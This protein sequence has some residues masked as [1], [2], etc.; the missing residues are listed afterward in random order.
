VILKF[1]RKILLACLLCALVP[2]GLAAALT[3]WREPALPFS[4]AQIRGLLLFFGLTVGL[5]FI[6]GFT[7]AF[8]LNRELQ[9]MLSELRTALNQVSP[10][11]APAGKAPLPQDELATLLAEVTRRLGELAA[12][13]E[14]TLE[15]TG[16]LDMSHLL[17]TIVARATTLMGVTGGFIYEADPAR[18]RLRLAAVKALSPDPLGAEMEFGEG[19]AGRVAESGESLVIH[20]YLQW[21]GR[22]ERFAGQPVFNV[23]GVPMRWQGQ[24]IGVLNLE[25]ELGGRR[26]TAPDV[27]LAEQ[28][29][30]QAA[31]AMGN[32]RL[33]AAANRQAERLAIMHQ[34]SQ[35]ILSRSLDLEQV[36]EAIDRAVGQLMPNEAMTIGLLDDQQEYVEA[37]YLRDRGVRQPTRRVSADASLTGYM[38]K[39][40]RPLLF[41]S[42]EEWPSDVQH[43]G[44]EESVQSVL[45]VPL[46]VGGYTLGVLTTQSYQPHA[47]SEDDFPL[48]MTLANQAAA[49][50]QNA[51]LFQSVQRQVLQL[52]ILHAVA[53]AAVRPAASDPEEV[54]R[55]AMETL[56][57]RVNY[58]FLA[59]LLLNPSGTA[60]RPYSFDSGRQPALPD[61]EI[62]L[63][64]GVTGRVA[65][66]G[67]PR[68][69]GDVTQEAGYLRTFAGARSE[70]CVPLKVGERVIGVLN[71]EASA[72]NAFGEEDERLLTIVAGL[73]A[74]IIENAELYARDRQRL[75]ELTLLT[76][77]ALAA[78]S[79]TT[80]D[81]VIARA[82][83]VLRERLKY[84]IVGVEL[85][86]ETGA[87]VVAHP[88]YLGV[89]VSRFLQPFPL[90]EGISGT[91]IQTGQAIRVEDVTRDA[92]Y[93][94][95]I[96]GIRSELAVPLKTAD[97]VI[98]AINTESHHE[99]AYTDTDERLL[100]VVAGMLAPIIENARLRAS[101]EQQA[102]DLDLLFRVQVAASASLD[103][104]TVLGGIV[105]QV[106][107]ALQVTSAYVI[108]LNGA[109]LRVVAEYYS[110]EASVPERVSDLNVWYPV[111]VFAAAARALRTGQP[112][113]I[114]VDDPETPET[115]RDHLR[116]Y[117]GRTGLIAPF[118][119]HGR[120]LGYLELWES[121]RDRVFSARE[122]QLAQTLAGS[123]AAALE[124]ATLYQSA[125]RQAEQMRLVN[126]VGRD[127][128][129]ILDMHQ[130]LAQVSL[131]LEAA[132]GYYHARVGLIE[133][134]DIV[135]PAR[136]A[137][138]AQRQL[139]EL[140]QRLAGP[141]IIAWV[142][143]HAEP[144]LVSD[145]RTDP[146]YL[147]NP[148]FPDTRALAAVP[149]IAS[150][151]AVGVLDVQS[152]RVGGLGKDD[153]TTLLAISGQLAVA[154]ENA[155]LYE[156]ARRR[157]E[158]VSALLA[159]T[160]DLGSSVELST[161]LDV[162]A[163]SARRLVDGDSC[164][165][166]KLDPGA[167]YLHPLVVHDKYAEQISAYKI[168]VGEG[169]TGMVALRGE[170]ELVNRAD[171]DPRG[172][173]F[174]GTPATPD[175]LLAVPLKVG[176]RITGVMAVYREGL[177]GFKLHDLNLITSFAAQA[178]VAIE[179]A[180]LYQALRERANSLQA[181]Y[182]QLA[183]MDRR[184]DE[185]V[186]NV[187]HELRTPLTFLRSYVELLLSGQLG[188]LL[189]E[190]EKS[191]RIVADKTSTLVR[192]V[193]DI[194]TLQA[195]TPATIKRI[196]L[197]LASVARAAAD[198]VQAA[199]EE[200]GLKL[201]VE[202]PP[203]P[204]PM[205]GD[206]LRL[207]QVFDNLLGNAVK[208]THR[209]GEIHVSVKPGE[210]EARVEVRDTGIGIA[211]DNL[212]HVF[213]RFYQVD[214]SRTRKR[215]G[216]GLGLSICRLIVEAHGGRIGAES[217]LDEGSSFYF[218]LPITDWAEGAALYDEKPL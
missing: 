175:N 117:G 146:D 113:Q 67:Q 124:N 203:R 95:D 187:S 26:F 189:P 31:A 154:V 132:F 45:A 41:H 135:F 198:G 209:G 4:P 139:P 188:E 199:A 3:L 43:Y 194:L 205:E 101:A 54:T 34:A 165:I 127:V 197:D 137:A 104:E 136:P 93:R 195:V 120:P 152:K 178:A 176:R 22:S 5:A 130:L 206:P 78:I 131:R 190:Q 170:G 186:Q 143:Q 201:V 109:Q 86:D 18:R 179:N 56:S 158:E 144:R 115:E 68:R 217:Q 61:V 159:T 214:G 183:E 42:A 2:L 64:I 157:A 73:L 216:I 80:F 167:E 192:L 57:Q 112:G 24:L 29:A 121:R 207:T 196:P 47:F 94:P 27:A 200:A 48:L 96:P 147:P 100:T 182:N 52:S 119:R 85:L 168:N 116:Q 193:N 122:V 163:Q 212:E 145:A 40:R 160:I 10:G 6:L 140:R 108:E 161:R 76:D 180:E 184:K 164:I 37:V 173:T 148:T 81:E 16:Q 150:G 49:A 87:W 149:L 59:L 79:A 134:E 106:G 8:L 118:V 11:L 21:V 174:P 32:A 169:I 15:L 1:S 60:L 111:E 65:Q 102:H 126:E 191:L 58:D 25:D 30:H 171:L 50:I 153:V 46:Q 181:A 125:R 156:E 213:D 23:L 107:R 215:G 7:A 142:A 13:R 35:D 62:P 72:P 74:P 128:A 77:V 92:R 91:A 19:V 44:G 51:R 38:L 66:T 75:G 84:E 110:P 208:F 55:R 151:H 129:G 210:R 103:L 202:L 162:I 70:L 218:T 155:R 71:A 36:Y 97:R 172:K 211:P 12:L 28:F 82:L 20:N 63:G 9:R 14:T 133:G 88:S 141:G 123:V 33:Y 138:R 89:D 69:I 166:Y 99:A 105:E 39:S 114:G 204:V 53:Q 177:R 17:Q 83:Q 98:G 185:M 90:T